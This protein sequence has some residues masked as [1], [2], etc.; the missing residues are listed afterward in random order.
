MAVPSRPPASGL[1][2]VL[3]A[4][5]PALLSFFTSRTGDP[6]EAE[7]ILLE[8]ARELPRMV[9]GPVS[10]PF[11]YIYRIGLRLV[12]DRLRERQSRATQPSVVER[13]F[14]ERTVEERTGRI[15]GALASMPPAAARAFHLR[16]IEGYSHREVANRLGLTRK[17]VEHHMAMAFRHLA[18]ELKE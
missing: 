2:A 3:L 16:K 11:G 8:I 13:P 14:E 9:A 5:R 17:G 7:A 1:E 10:D 15:A 18:Q 12:V 4:H 6:A